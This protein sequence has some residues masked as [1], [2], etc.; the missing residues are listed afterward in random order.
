MLHSNTHLNLTPLHPQNPQSVPDWGS[1]HIVP[2]IKRMRVVKWNFTHKSHQLKHL[3]K[4]ITCELNNVIY[5]IILITYTKCNMHYVGETSRALIKR[6]YGKK[7][8]S[9]KMDNKHQYH[10]LSKAMKTT[11][12][13]CSS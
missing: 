5:L 4:H 1:A 3:P 7:H 8:H 2:F 13:I 6:M 10:T 11:P 9:K 12:D